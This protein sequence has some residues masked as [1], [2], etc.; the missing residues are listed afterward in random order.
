MTGGRER[1]TQEYRQLLDRAGFKLER[2][3]PTE[4]SVCVLEAVKRSR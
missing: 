2:I 4:S 3:V 1:T